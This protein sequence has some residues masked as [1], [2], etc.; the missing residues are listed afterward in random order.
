MLGVTAVAVVSLAACGGSKST[1]TTVGAAARSAA[2]TPAARLTSP[3]DDS[4]VA[5]RQ[6]V[7]G[8]VTGLRPSTEAWIVVYPALAPAY[9]PQA[10]PLQPGPAGVFL[11]LA[12]FGVPN[13]DVGEH[14]TVRL[15]ITTPAAS[16]RIRAFL[17]Q[18]A[19]RR[20]MPSLPPGA[21]TLTQ[22]TVTR[23]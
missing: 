7:G 12:F 5:Y 8:V 23:S 3:R 17:A 15:V 10:G 2:G 19:P 1:P 21:Q 18:P 4:K 13:Q 20:G 22:V 9:W 14:F 16:A 11:T 6:E